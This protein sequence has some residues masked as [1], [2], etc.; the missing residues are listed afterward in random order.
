[1]TSRRATPTGERSVEIRVPALHV[2]A[3]CVCLRAVPVLDAG[4]VNVWRLL[5]F[6]AATCASAA[7][8]ARLPPTLSPIMCVVEAGANSSMFAIN[9]DTPSAA[10]SII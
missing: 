5:A 10:I 8:G 9:V 1:M 3:L 7:W 4:S 6:I 2:D